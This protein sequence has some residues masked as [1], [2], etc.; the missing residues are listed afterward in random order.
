MFPE[1]IAG[2]KIT[3]NVQTVVHGNDEGLLVTFY[4]KAVQNNF[5]SEKEGRPIFDDA[6]FVR[7]VTP[8]DA[9]N[10]FDQKVRED[11][12]QRFARQWEA[13]KSGQEV[14]QSG[15]P[16]EAWVRMTPSK[17]MMYKF[18]GI[19]TVEGVANAADSNAKYLP[20]DWHDDR[21]AARAYL[22]SAEDS[23]VVQRQAAELQQ[24]DDEI[25]NLKRQ[26]EELA[27]LVKGA[28]GDKPKGKK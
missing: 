27:T 10:I 15:T 26:M 9:S 25:A 17:I 4:K 3:A 6:D 13:Y 14:S 22:Q 8:G 7:I 24:R 1:P 16:L 18:A 28:D 20:M 11:H 2:Q 19:A 21:L 5:K 23:S 12:K